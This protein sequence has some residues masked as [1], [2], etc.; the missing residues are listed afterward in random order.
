[1]KQILS[2]PDISDNKYC[3]V[4]ILVAKTFK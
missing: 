3:H 1:V 4:Q 2:C